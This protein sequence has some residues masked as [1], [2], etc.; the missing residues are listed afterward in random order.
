MKID[1]VTIFPEILDGP[2]RESMIKRAVEKDLVKINLVDLREYTEDRHR[3]VD[4]T[5]YG[6]G[7][8]M[9]M[10]PEPIFRAVE[11]LRSNNMPVRPRVILLTP[12]GRTFNQQTAFELAREE[13]LIMI[14]GRYEGIDERVRIG[15]ADDEISIGDYVLT[16]GELAAAVITEAV[17]RL[18]PGFLSEEA[19]VEESFTEP[20]LEYPHYTK[21]RVY[22][23]MSVPEVLL[24]GNHREIAIW[25]RRQSL[26][27]TYN[28]RPDLLKKAELTPEDLLYLQVLKNKEPA[29]Q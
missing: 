12:R 29:G 5:P 8:G 10:K 11:D 6:G 7:Y 2:F 23:E 27:R 16:G 9:V 13:H 18:L 28:M 25:R 21:P 4:D 17:V 24:S 3:Q 14:C 19:R 1:L 15:L 26:E 22:R 20:L